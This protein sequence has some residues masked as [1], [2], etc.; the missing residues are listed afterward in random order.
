MNQL[1]SKIK[2]L[3]YALAKYAGFFHLCKFSMKNK[4]R[5]L[6]YHGLELADE[7]D[8]LPHSFIKA[9][10][11]RKRLQ[12]IRNHKFNVITLQELYSHY[13]NNTIPKNCVVITF[14][15]GFYS[16]FR[17]AVPVLSEF[18]YKSTLYLTSYYFDSS[19]PIYTLTLQYLFWKAIYSPDHY[20]DE[21]L[22]RFP[23]CQID[24][25]NIVE[26]L[27]DI[28][29]SQES[30]RQRD[31]ILLA[32]ADILSVDVENIIKDRLFG[33]ITASE[34]DQCINQGMNIELHTHRHNFP[35]EPSEAKYE[36]KKNRLKVE[37]ITNTKMEHFCYPR[38]V[39]NAAHWETLSGLGIKT[40][41]TC[42]N[43]LIDEK[44][45][46]FA[47]NRLL[48]SSKLSQ[49]EFEAD[50]MGFKELVRSIKKIITG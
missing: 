5:I 50:L 45:P 28:G 39:W 20:L 43:G 18:N 24:T 2:I 21:I 14:D 10:V 33:L 22:E 16:I 47:W 46:P 44:T 8:Y 12:L 11:F 36:I 25:N 4:A 49:I 15:D 1:K 26:S 37:P 41:T 6:C 9:D 29:Q 23:D 32:V 30:N 42:E 48:D 35:I 13:I 3:V 7:C 17:R 38:G 31:K 19:S 40:A 27:C 34:A